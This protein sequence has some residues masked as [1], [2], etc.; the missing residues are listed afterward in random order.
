M[1]ALFYAGLLLAIA[2]AVGLVRGHVDTRWITSRTRSAVPLAAGV[3][4]MFTAAA[5]P[6]H[7]AGSVAGRVR[8]PADAAT[9]I[10][11]LEPV[12]RQGTPAAHDVF[13]EQRQAF[14]Q[15]ERQLLRAHARADAAMQ[16]ASDV[17]AALDTGA[18][19]RFTAW[20]RLGALAQDVNQ[21]NLT[22]HDLTPPNVLDLAERKTLEDG[23][24]DL[25]RGLDHKR[26]GLR[27]L[28]EFVRTVETP[29]LDRA[30]TEIDRGHDAMVAGLTKVLR[31]KAAL[32]AE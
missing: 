16:H 11:V 28:R 21:A 32:A 18:I 7:A 12:V 5:P 27:Y 8:T 6:L 10:S 17:L 2:G 24:K 30:Q 3:V 20:V 25:K 23:L 9:V 26:Q 13:P 22:L 14:P 31:V 1:T 15:W 19:D 29:L 4:L